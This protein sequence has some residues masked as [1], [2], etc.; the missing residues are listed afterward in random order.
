MGEALTDDE[1]VIFTKLT[2][3]EREPGVRCFILLVI[4]GRRGGKSR[5]ISCLVVFL[6]VFF[7]HGAKLAPGNGR[8]CSVWL[9]IGSKPR[10]FTAMSRASLRLSHYW[11]VENA[12]PRHCRFPTASR[13][14]L[15][16][17]RTAA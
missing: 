2:G 4:A 5:A 15:G 6:A 12:T 7:D 9:K 1:R 14:R 13:F 3:R 10:S 8:C 11:L 17:L 16:Q